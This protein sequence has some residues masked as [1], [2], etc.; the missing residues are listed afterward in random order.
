MDGTAAKLDIY[1]TAIPM[2]TFEH[3]ATVRDVAEAITV[4]LELADGRTGWGQTHPR[5]YV[6][7]E[8]IES[9]LADISDL[10]WPQYCDDPARPFPERA[11][12]GR[13]INAAACALELAHTDA[14]RAFADLR[15]TRSPIDARVSGVLGSR[16]PARTAKR[17]KLMRLFGLRDFK[18]KL[19][20]GEQIDAANLRV[21]SR[22]LGRAIAA[23]RC[24]LRA[25]VNGAWDPGD[26]PQRVAELKVAGVCVVE[27]PVFC[28]AEQLV[29]LAR[30][31]EL[32]LMA[33]ESLLTEADATALLAEPQRIWWNIRISKNGGVKRAARLAQMA[34]ASGVSFSVGCMV[35]ESGILSAAQR[36]LLQLSPEPRFV[37]GNYGKF[38]MKGDLTRPSPRFAYGGR[39]KPLAGAGLGVTVHAGLIARY[40]KLLRTLS[41]GAAE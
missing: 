1:R 33:D 14:T 19:G 32:P 34:A 30:S 28:P 3:A 27:Q 6:T 8:T 16:D 5:P 12:E 2:R 23:G 35:G 41:A 37:E 26:V 18:L 24:T 39:L 31:C 21:V 36:R 38:L 20:L 29:E 7:G 22:L 15:Q 13:V 4:R 11:A 10:L 17:L 9:V 25:D 40:G